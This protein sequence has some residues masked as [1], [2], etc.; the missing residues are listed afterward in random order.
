MPVELLSCV[1]IHIFVD[2]G[3]EINSARIATLGERVEDTFEVTR[4]HGG[5]IAAGE[6]AYQLQATIRQHIDQAVKIPGSKNEAVRV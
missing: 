2:L 4:Q 1:L 6:D 3:L 5:P